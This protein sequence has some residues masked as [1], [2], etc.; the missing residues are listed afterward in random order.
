MLKKGEPWPT[1]LPKA[2]LRESFLARLLP[3]TRLTRGAMPA[4][5]R[6]TPQSL[7]QHHWHPRRVRHAAL[8]TPVPMTRVRWDLGLACGVRCRP[9][10]Q[11]LTG[12]FLLGIGNVQAERKGALPPIQISVE[13]RQGNKVSSTQ[14]F[15]PLLVGFWCIRLHRHRITS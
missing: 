9:C 4:P 3:T 13:K 1:E 15:M 14:Q 11:T 12:L 8:D 7:Q 10:S 2:R 6:A 5:H